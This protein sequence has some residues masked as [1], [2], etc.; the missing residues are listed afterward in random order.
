[1]HCGN[2]HIFCMC[3]IPAVAASTLDMMALKSECASKAGKSCFQKELASRTGHSLCSHVQL[4][5]DRVED[6]SNQW[7]A[8]G[9][10]RN[11]Y[12]DEGKAVDEV[13]GACAADDVFFLEVI[14][15]TGTTA[16][17]WTRPDTSPCPSAGISLHA[18]R[19]SDLPSMGSIIQVGSSVS[20]GA[21]PRAAVS[22]SPM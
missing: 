18:A 12:A 21:P 16:M 22:S 10:Q 11:A 2:K 1:M 13:A 7:L 14:S 15:C 6:H 20:S 4:V 17:S 9:H 5:H 19:T 3:H 8:F